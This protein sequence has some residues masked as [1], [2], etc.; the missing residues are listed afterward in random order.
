M[1]PVIGVVGH[2]YINKDDNLIFQTTNSIVK[3]ISEHGG[4]PIIICPTQIED[5]V[6]KKN[7]NIRPLTFFEK[8]D[9]NEI[10]ELCDGIIKPGGV[11]IYGY[12]RYIYEYTYNNDIPYLGICAGMQMMAQHSG[13]QI[14]IKNDSNINHCT[15]QKYAHKIKIVHGTLLYKILQQD[16][17]IVNSLHNYHIVNSGINK[18]NAYSLDGIIEGIENPNKIFHLGLQWHPEGLDD[19]NS[20]KIFDSFIETSSIYKKKIKKYN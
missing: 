6:H 2:P 4:L 9:L 16:E 5:F 14:N 8:K 1:K 3:K 18:T 11:R 12:E 13:E 15:K 19:L 17:I 7:N 20:N 10:L